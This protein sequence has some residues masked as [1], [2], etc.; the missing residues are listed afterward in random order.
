MSAERELR[1]Q[2]DAVLSGAVAAGAVA[3]VAAILASD[4]GVIY[5]GAAGVRSL[6]GA[7]PMDL[8]TVCWIAS[9][10]KPLTS[11]AAVQ[12]VERGA[13]KLDAPAS[14][15]APE[16]CDIAVLTG[17]DEA[18]APQLRPP[19]RPVTMR[20]LLTHTS[21]FGYE[22]FS[23]DVVKAQAALGLPGLSTGKIATL[24][25]PLLFDPGE[26]WEYGVGID[27]AGRMVEAISGK[28][29]G[30]YLHENVFEPLGMT[31]TAFKISPEMRSRLAG[32][33]L[34]VGD[35][36][37]PLPFES[38]Q[39]PEFESGGGGLYSTARDYIR[40][41]EMILGGGALNGRRLVNPSSMALLT[42]N[43]MANLRVLPLKTV[44]PLSL[45]ADFFAGTPKGWSLAFEVNLEAVPTGRAT[46]GL[47]WAGLSNCYF[48]IDPR[49]RLG[50]VVFA[51]VL[52]F[53]DPKALAVWHDFETAAYRSRA[54]S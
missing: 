15:V 8:D 13:L 4:R 50:G 12:L 36:L 14:E 6:G 53:A 30:A 5:E 21:G 51:Q 33:H 44:T 18:G 42:E 31:S 35:V 10:T 22:L 39:D 20:Q 24:R 43:Q 32:M 28:K 46:G 38:A 7:E 17:F 34:R 47:M 23:G 19:K 3:G 27:W 45:D 16:L 2:A 41:V 52:P 11:L 37:A 29:L 1:N 40:F 26:R 9:M 49:S 48:W 25:A 54:G